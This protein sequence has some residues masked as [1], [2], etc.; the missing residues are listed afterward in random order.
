[1]QLNMVTRPGLS[2]NLLSHNLIKEMF[3]T[4]IPHIRVEVEAAST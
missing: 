2:L 3:P 4:P 1:M